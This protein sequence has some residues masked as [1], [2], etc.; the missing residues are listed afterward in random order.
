MG[1]LVNFGTIIV[2]GLLGVLF[3]KR[4]KQEL[5][6]LLITSMSICLVFVAIIGIIPRMITISSE[7]NGEFLI[8]SHGT[9]CLIISLFVGTLVGHFLK[10]ND[11]LDKFGIWVEN[12][13]KLN[14]FSE[15]FVPS[16]LF[17]CVG[18]MAIL[19]SI[20]EGVYH[21]YDILICKSVIDFT[22]A[23]AMGSSLGY[24]VIFSAI[25]ILLYE[26]GLTLCAKALQGVLVTEVG[27]NILNGIC[28]VGYVIIFA[29]ALNMMKIK[30]IKTGD[31][32]PAMLIP[33]IYYLI[34]SLTNFSDF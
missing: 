34:L 7:E 4:I 27:A 21:K 13:L 32:I 14:G 22:V 2:G 19:G 8:E 25:P 16:T 9:L 26:G 6:D 28:M 3:K 31:L 11:N 18:A 23:I 33:I 5:T 17:F 1:A 10:I 30:T 15:G 24:G 20:Q 29:I 12:K